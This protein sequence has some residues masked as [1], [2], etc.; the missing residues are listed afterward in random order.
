[1]THSEQYLNETAEIARTMDRAEIEFLA[2]HLAV[3]RVKGGRLF[4]VGLGGS[5]ANAS[6]AANDFVKLCAL[7]TICLTDNTAEFTACAN[8]SGWE[9]A[10]VAMLVARNAGHTDALL[11]LSVGGGTQNVSGAIVKAINKAR[12]LGCEI[13]GIV[14]PEGGYT[15]K[16]GT[17]VVK[18]PAPL[19]RITPHT[20]AFQAVVWH[21]LVSHSWLQKRATVW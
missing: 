5:A 17:C 13:L 3:L 19:N 12:Y 16:H 1:M 15:A 2:S 18:V 14:G 20:E 10:F 8:D 11:V 6:H 7:D 4:I 9:N 21:A